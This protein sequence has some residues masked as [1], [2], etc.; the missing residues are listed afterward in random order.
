MTAY[1]LDNSVLQRLDRSP[2]V[3][4]AT[5]SLMGRADLLAT[6]D[7]S[8]LE[9]GF[10]A[11]SANDHSR[12]VESLGSILLR[13]PLTPEIG[14]LALELQSS[15]FAAGLGRAVGI[16]DLL[17]AATAIVHEAIVV[18]YDSDFETLAG[19]EGRLRQVWIV[20]PGS[21]D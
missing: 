1:L 4:D 14:A 8:V 16:V 20:P 5:E 19:V 18:H 11:V 10:S 21:V 15:L 13:L 17:H 2:A 6:T 12:I 3:L 9:A 7:V